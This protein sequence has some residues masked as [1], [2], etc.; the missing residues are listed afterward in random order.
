M[1]FARFF[2]LVLCC[3]WIVGCGDPAKNSSEKPDTSSA[4]NAAPQAV[5]GPGDME[6]AA[7]NT[8]AQ[9]TAG[10]VTAP[11]TTPPAGFTPVAL[12]GG[13]A[14][15]S[16]ENTTIQVIGQH[17]PPR[18]DGPEDRDAR[19]IVFE[20]FSGSIVFDQATKLPKSATAEI[21]ATSLV[22]FDAR[23]TSH[24]KNRDFIEVEAYPTIKFESSRIEPASEPGKVTIIG[25]L[26]LKDVTK[27][28]TIPA[29]VTYDGNGVTVHGQVKL[30][31]RDFNINAT[32]ID[33]STQPEFDFTLAV[34][35]KTES[36]AGGR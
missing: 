2:A 23:L 19:T 16:P 30:N 5:P 12:E 21:D 25:K 7:D 9:P 28:V 24:L 18:G 33:S 29:T 13:V 22:A 17:N 14:K 20:K 11:P 34:G 32:R 26:T 35:K 6:R 3:S 8:T 1:R 15:L 36:P 31:R 27:E 10:P 4:P